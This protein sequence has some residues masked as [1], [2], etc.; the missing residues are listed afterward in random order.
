MRFNVE[1]PLTVRGCLLAV[2]LVECL[3]LDPLTCEYLNFDL[4][5]WLKRSE[6]NNNAVTSVGTLVQLSLVSNC[7]GG[8][9]WSGTSRS[10]DQ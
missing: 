6:F 10:L 3:C 5:L 1:L 4:L 9:L 2:K 8:P 7:V